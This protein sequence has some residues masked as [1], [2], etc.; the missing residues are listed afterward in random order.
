MDYSEVSVDLTNEDG[1]EDSKLFSPQDDQE[2]VGLRMPDGMAAWE[3]GDDIYFITANE[4]DA[5]EY[6][7]S[8]DVYLDEIR[9]KDLD[10]DY[11]TVPGRLKL[12]TSEVYLESEEETTGQNILVLANE[13]DLG[14]DDPTNDFLIRQKAPQSPRRSLQ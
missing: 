9:N 2:V 13:E 4:G 1:P 14:D 3:Q 11:S 7:T 8:D 12:I 6:E 10:P 5:R